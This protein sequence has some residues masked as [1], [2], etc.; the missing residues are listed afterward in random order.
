MQYLKSV[1][2]FFKMPK[3][4]M[5]LLLGSICAL[6]PMVGP[7]VLYGWLIGLF[8]ARRD[9]ENPENYPPFDFQHFTKYL[10]RG[11][12]P[13]VVS[14]VAGIVLVPVIMVIVFAFMIVGAALSET[15]ELGEAL[16]ALMFFIGFIAYIVVLIGFGILLTPLML[17]AMITQDFNSAFDLQFAKRFFSLVWAE[18]LKSMLFLC[19][20]GILSTAV[21]ACT[22]YLGM[23]FVPA[24]TYFSWLHIQKQLY[25]LY[26][27]RGGEPV[28]LSEK[29]NDV[30]PAMPQS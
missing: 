15:S 6:I 14:L 24:L 27:G 23:F 2:D 20:L 30:P 1:T 8:W 3:C 25:K 28:P 10:E 12:W 29:L 13:F 11:L 21:I 5:S 7:I 22:C 4:G 26:L 9:D 16:A 17:K 19:G 18:T